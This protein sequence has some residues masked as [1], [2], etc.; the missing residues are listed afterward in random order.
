MDSCDPCRRAHCR[1]EEARLRVRAVQGLDQRRGRG[2]GAR[3]DARGA[4][5][6]YLGT[7]R[8][9]VCDQNTSEQATKNYKI[10]NNYS[11]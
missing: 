6:L 9:R 4:G 3:E 10:P 1:G 2:P 8:E 7:H 11:T 5:E